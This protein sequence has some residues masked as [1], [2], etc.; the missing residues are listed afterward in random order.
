M[1]LLKALFLQIPLF[2][3]KWPSALGLG[4]IGDST[5]VSEYANIIRQEYNAIG[6]KLALG[7]MADV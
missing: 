3:S 2:F 6:I 1:V 7:P 5:T 4:A